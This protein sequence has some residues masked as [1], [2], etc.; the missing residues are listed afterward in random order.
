MLAG[1]DQEALLD[2]G[3]FV[4]KPHLLGRPLTRS[5]D[6]PRVQRALA[7]IDLTLQILTK[8]RWRICSLCTRAFP[9]RRKTR[10]C[11]P[12]RRR[13][14]RR[15]IQ[16]RLARAPQTP[17]ALWI[18]MKRDEPASIR[19]VHRFDRSVTIREGEG[20]WTPRVILALA[21]DKLAPPSLKRAARRFPSAVAS[22]ARR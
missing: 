17:V 13:F 10:T 6:S 21:D 11:P 14:S 2:A 12:C 19:T 20:F 3:A 9:A 7:E 16:W 22:G 8:S 4:V 5:D 1:T 18:W 15:Q